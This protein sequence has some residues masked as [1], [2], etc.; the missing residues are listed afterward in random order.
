MNKRSQVV[1]IIALW[2]IFSNVPGIYK[3][4]MAGWDLILSPMATVTWAYYLCA[5][6]CALG[7]LFYKEWARRSRK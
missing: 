4:V 3:D 1:V 5:F 6:I 2:L 7:L